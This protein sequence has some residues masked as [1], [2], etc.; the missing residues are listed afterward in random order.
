MAGGCLSASSV[1]HGH[2]LSQSLMRYLLHDHPAFPGLL[3]KED[4]FVLVERGAL[5]HGD[6][7]TDTLTR[8]DHTVGEVIR[9]M[10]PPRGRSARISRP[11][12]QEI[13]ADLPGFDIR[14]DGEEEEEPADADDGT[15]PGEGPLFVA[16]PSWL[17]YSGGFMAVALLAGLGAFLLPF[18][19]EYSL[20]PFLAALAWLFGITLARYSTDYLVDEDRVEKVWGLL[21]RSSREVRICDVRNIDVHMRGLKGLLGVGTVDISSAGSSDVEVSFRDVRGA[22]EVKQLVRQLQRGAATEP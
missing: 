15:D 17:A 4:L 5:A 10:A 19:G 2:G 21:A 9:G 7:C 11:A 12:Y 3:S 1:H 14:L 13:R 16:H 6:L 8:R 22:H 18:G 20:I